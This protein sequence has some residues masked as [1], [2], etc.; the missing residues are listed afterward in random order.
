MSYSLWRN[1]QAAWIGM[2]AGLALVPAVLLAADR[3]AK[4]A[5][6]DPDA[7]QVDLFQALDDGDIGVK[8]IMKDSK[9]GKLMIQNKTDKPLNVKLP[10]AFG[11]VPILAQQNQNRNNNNNNNGAQAMG[12][13]GGMGGMGGGMGGGMFFVAPEKVAQAQLPG[14]CLEHGKQEP[15]PAI[16]YEIKPIEKVTDKPEVQELCRMLGK[17]QINQR[18]AQVAAWHL[19]NNMSWQTLAAKRLKFANGTSQPYFSPQEIQAGMQ[20]VAAATKLVEDR[21]K[22]QPAST[23]N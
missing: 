7:K 23:A 22:Q 4:R 14:V 20:I 1:W 11:A 15:R 6:A 17:G 18:A 19:N 9:E 13:G 3:P 5:A 2:L 12:M 16:Q 8:M 21:Q 10:E